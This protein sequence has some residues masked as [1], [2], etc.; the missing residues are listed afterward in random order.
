MKTNKTIVSRNGIT[1]FLALAALLAVGLACGKGADAKPIP[2]EYHGTWTSTDGSTISIR[3]DGSGDYVAGSTKVTGGNVAIEGDKLSVTLLGMGPDFKI[4]K[5]PSGNKMTLDG[6]VYTRTGGGPPADS[7]ST[8]DKPTIPSNDK[9]QS[10]VKAT[11]MDFGDAIQEE[12]FTDFHK[13]I[14]KVWRDDTTP[15]ELNDAFKVFINDKANYDFKKAISPLGATFEPAPAIQTVSGLEA[16]VLK[17]FY[18]TKPRRSNFELKYVMDDGTW[19]LIGID[20]NTK[21]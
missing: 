13:K 20:V 21:N 10:L 17:G 12:D 9:L 19:K 1:I 5:A 11:F 14:A 18:P 7:S 3:A 2:V 8:G 15:D 6:V 4:D 16:L